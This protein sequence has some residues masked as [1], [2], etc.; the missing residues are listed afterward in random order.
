MKT[1]KP[2]ST[3]YPPGASHTLQEIAGQAHPTASVLKRGAPTQWRANQ[4]APPQ[5]P[6]R[7]VLNNCDLSGCGAAAAAALAPRLPLQVVR[8]Q[9]RPVRLRQ[10]LYNQPPRTHTRK[11]EQVACHRC[12]DTRRA[13]ACTHGAPCA[14]LLSTASLSTTC[15]ASVVPGAMAARSGP[16][17]RARA[18]AWRASRIDAATLG[19]R[20]LPSSSFTSTTWPPTTSDKRSSTPAAQHLWPPARAAP[21]R[22][23]QPCARRPR[24]QHP[25][26][27]GR[28]SRCSAGARGQAA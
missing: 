12:C 7:T 26:S 27:P 6:R 9:V 18:R 28:A 23:A 17:A 21:S 10:Q 24:A 22:A 19:P 15:S 25:R 16:S 2:W 8:V 14:L 3:T 1:H 5:L 13:T 4:S 11:A 20:P